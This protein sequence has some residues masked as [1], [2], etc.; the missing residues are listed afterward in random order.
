MSDYVES[1]PSDELHVSLAVP[2]HT[3]KALY[4]WARDQQWPEGTELEKPEE[5]HCTLLYSKSGSHWRDHPWWINH[6]DMSKAKIQSVESFGPAD[7]GYAYVLTLD[8]PEIQ[9]HGQKMTDQAARMGLEITHP[10][11]KPH[12]T[13]GY[14]PAKAEGI[15][16]PNFELHLGPSSISEPRTAHAAPEPPNLREGT[17]KEHCGNCT[18]YSSGQCWGYGN[19]DVDS[20][21]VC[22]SW[23]QESKTSSLIH[24]ADRLHTR[25]EKGAGVNDLV[26]YAERMLTRIGYSPDDMNTQAAIQTWQSL[27]PQDQLQVEAAYPPPG[28]THTCPNCGQGSV[29]NGWTGW[30]GVDESGNA[31]A[32]RS[33][34]CPQ[35]GNSHKPLEG[36]PVPRQAAYGDMNS[37]GALQNSGTLPEDQELM[38]PAQA[39]TLN[40]HSGANVSWLGQAGPTPVL[41][42]PELKNG[43]VHPES[44][45]AERGA[46]TLGRTMGLQVPPTVAQRVIAP[47]SPYNSMPVHNTYA[48]VHKFIPGARTV[49]DHYQDAF[50]FDKFA[51]DNPELA[52]HIGMFDHILG[53]GD[54]HLGNIIIGD[55]GQIHPIDHGSGFNSE[56][57]FYHPDNGNQLYMMNHNHPLTPQEQQ[58][59]IQAREHISNPAFQ[60]VVSPVEAHHAL[61]RLNDMLNTG[62]FHVQ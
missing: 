8:S 25:F 53:Q 26:G 47:A 2:K 54:R 34:D 27:Y 60:N 62:R 14:G 44:V 42:K 12:I 4:R 46:Y 39:Q 55:D 51:M 61:G 38:Q 11:F 49:A 37:E 3:A 18:M 31:V 33:W 13:V 19:F 23:E 35:C 43:N 57:K 29:S 10:E 32:D 5:Y 45:R 41:I 36:R 56:N 1:I 48:S 30:T 6:L 52:R 22:D 50:A 16:V 28:G 40:P 17:L 20:D 58:M 9:E 7:K 15:Q 59:L 21:D 24:V